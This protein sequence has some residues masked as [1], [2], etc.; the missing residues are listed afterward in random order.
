VYVT[1]SVSVITTSA[2]EGDDVSDPL[3]GARVV[4]AAAVELALVDPLDDEPLRSRI[5]TANAIAAAP[6]ATAAVVR[7]ARRSSFRVF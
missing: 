5:G 4:G 2:V 7:K 1:Y 3:D 6:P